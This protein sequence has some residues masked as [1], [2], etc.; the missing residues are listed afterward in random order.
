M[1]VENFN[2]TNLKSWNCCTISSLSSTTAKFH[3]LLDIELSLCR[4]C[5][6]YWE[7]KPLA[8]PSNHVEKLNK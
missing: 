6:F 5:T 4:S 1:S 7:Y 3:P 8:P 2:M